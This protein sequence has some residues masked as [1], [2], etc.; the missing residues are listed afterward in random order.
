[1]NQQ[2]L[3]IDKSYFDCCS[4]ISEL[5]VKS[6]LG[7]PMQLPPSIESSMDEEDLLQLFFLIKGVPYECVVR[8]NSYNHET[9]LDQFFIYS[10]YAPKGTADWLWQRDCFVLVEMGYPGDPR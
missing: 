10:V 9:D 4:L 6:S 2:N 7:E 3:N 1:M 8:D 5:H